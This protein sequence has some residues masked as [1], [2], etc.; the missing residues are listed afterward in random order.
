MFADFEGTTEGG[1]PV[2]LYE[3][4]AAATVWRF[5]SSED[6][7]VYNTV[8]WNAITIRR[9]KI[10]STLDSDQDKLEVEMDATQELPRRFLQ[11]VPGQIVNLTIYRLHR[12]DPDQ[13]AITIYRGAV[14]AASF[15]KQGHAVN[16]Q[17][18]PATQAFSRAV[19]RFT[20]SSL[21]SHMLYDARCKISEH[22]PDFEKF[23][24][25]TAINGDIITLTGAGGFGADFFVQ[26]FVHFQGDF[27]MVTAQ[28]GDDLTLLVPFATSPVGFTIRTL[29]GCKLRLIADCTDKF[30]NQINF[31]GFPYVP[32]RNPFT[33]GIDA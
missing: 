24:P 15:V 16:L 4:R 29:A 32:L 26:G 11:T 6:D 5:T 18:L 10:A 27:R 17:V 23:L 2:E 21:C 30:N 25:C 20:F 8:T 31:G 28:S 9:G 14:H 13:E 12:E 7:Y 22:D 19:P 3:F 33:S 1:R